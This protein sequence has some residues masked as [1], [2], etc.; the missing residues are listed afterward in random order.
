MLR[1]SRRV[2]SGTGDLP[3]EAPFPEGQVELVPALGPAQIV[4]R[5]GIERLPVAI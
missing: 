2:I 3:I 1:P 5:S 4:M